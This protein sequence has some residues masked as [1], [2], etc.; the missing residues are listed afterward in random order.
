M[1]GSGTPSSRRSSRS[2]PWRA[3]KRVP[4]DVRD[5]FDYLHDEL[6]RRLAERKTELLGP[7][8]GATN[9]RALAAG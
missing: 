7:E 5:R 9:R 6:V 8:A 2:R 3:A 4:H 1:V